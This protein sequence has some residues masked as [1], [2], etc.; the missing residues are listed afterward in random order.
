MLDHE[1]QRCRP[2]IGAP[3]QLQQG[4]LGQ[5]LAA[6][7]RHVAELSRRDLQV[8]DAQAHHLTRHAA[9]TDWPA[10]APGW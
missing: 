2:A 9:A 10:G 6:Q 1:H 4:F 5:R 3:V 7:A 8:I